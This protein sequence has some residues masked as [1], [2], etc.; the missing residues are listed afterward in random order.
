MFN[1]DTV[2]ASAFMPSLET[3]ARS[4]KVEPIIAHIYSEIETSSPW[5]ASREAALSSCRMGS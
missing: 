3:A 4:I 1:P 5:G 2:T